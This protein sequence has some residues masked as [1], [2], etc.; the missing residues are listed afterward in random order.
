MQ[1]NRNSAKNEA[2]PSKDFAYDRVAD[3]LRL[4]AE[5]GNFGFRIDGPEILLGQNWGG[6]G[7]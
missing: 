4:T 6:G 5:L 1:K 2:V 7:G 3:L